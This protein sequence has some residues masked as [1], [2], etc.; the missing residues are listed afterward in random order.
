MAKVTEGVFISYRRDGGEAMAQLIHD[1]L[2]ARGL[3]VFY[4]IESLS[5]GLFD[6]KLLEKIEACSDVVLILPAQG[7]DRCMYEEDWVRKEIRHALKCKKNIVPLMLRGFDFP[8]NLPEDISAISRF[9]GIRMDTMDYLDAKIDKLVSMLEC[10]PSEKKD[11][12]NTENHTYNNSGAY[13][14]ETKPSLIA[15]VCTIGTVDRN[16]LW[17]K[18][19]YSPTI[20]LDKYNAVRF[21]VRLVKPFDISKTVKHGFRIYEEG[22]ALVLDET[23]EIF[24][25]NDYTTYSVGWIIRGTD[26]SYIKA[27]KYRAE[28]WIDDSRTY[29]INFRVISE[30]QEGV[31]TGDRYNYANSPLTETESKRK[32]TLEGYLI[33]P[34]LLLWLILELVVLFS[35]AIAV[36]LESPAFPVIFSII[37]I[38][39]IVKVVKMIKKYVVSNLFIAILLGSF[40]SFYFSIYVAAMSLFYIVRKGAWQKELAELERRSL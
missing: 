39:I 20:D 4:D 10:K 35:T 29:S 12:N 38:L 30:E 24:M 6:T 22:G 19:A 23:S 37:W 11:T 26:G 1:R 31:R 34:K 40:V 16:E 9:N 3:T 21:H 7:L 28:F 15:N 18:G 14:T 32:K 2:V 13:N 27:G 36:A 25:R 8:S 17:P 5:S 33:M